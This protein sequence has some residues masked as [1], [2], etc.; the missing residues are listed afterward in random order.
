MSIS[1]QNSIPCEI[2]SADDLSISFIG[3]ELFY[4]NQTLRSVQNEFG[5]VAYRSDSL[6]AVKAPA[7]FASKSGKVLVVDQMNLEDLLNRPSEYKQAVPSGCLAF[8]YRKDDSARFLFEHWDRG[9]YG[10]IGYLPMNVAPDVWRAIL[11]LLMH[12]ELYLPSFLAD[13]VLRSPSESR[14]RGRASPKQPD[15]PPSSRK[16]PLYSKLTRR[17][18]Q[19]LRLVSQGKSN[20]TIAAKLGITE[21]TVKLHMHNVSGKIGVNNRTAAA[22]FYFEVA[23]EEAQQIS[24]D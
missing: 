5:V 22:H 13:C 4:S 2:E 17:E 10:D 21:H 19:V 6:D 11:R 23:P 15:A 3:K 12:E 24:C 1:M 9:R 8:A 20:K 18:K 16:N 14:N 7:S